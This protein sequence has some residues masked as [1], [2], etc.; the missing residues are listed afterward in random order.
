M[1][2]QDA[3]DRTRALSSMPRSERVTVPDFQEKKQR[4]EKIAVLTAYDAT[5]A[6]LLDR[7][8]VDALLVGD[9]VGM[10]VLGHESTIPVTLDEMVHHTR[11]VSRGAQRALVIADMPFLTFQVSVA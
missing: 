6:R 8:G 5:M 4:G 1:A 9:S 7:A 3:A 10:V 11:A 2:D